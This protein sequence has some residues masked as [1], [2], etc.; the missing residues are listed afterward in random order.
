M[1]EQMQLSIQKKKKHAHSL[2]YQ[3]VTIKIQLVNA[4]KCNL[5][6]MPHTFNEI[7]VTDNIIGRFY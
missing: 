2:E 1:L 5:A 6:K 3:N 7:I 4:Q